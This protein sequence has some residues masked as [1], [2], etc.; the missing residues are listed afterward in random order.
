[1]KRTDPSLWAALGWGDEIAHYYV[2]E[3][4]LKLAPDQILWLYEHVTDAAGT[5]AREEDVHAWLTMCNPI[6]WL[7]KIVRKALYQEADE[8]AVKG[9][10][11]VVTEE[12]FENNGETLGETVDFVEEERGGD[13]GD[14]RGKVAEGE[15]GVVTGA[16]L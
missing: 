2:V 4:M 15:L 16:Y 6:E 3:D 11:D 14:L 5:H 7:E 8:E 1:M 13:K 12:W 10:V 9:V